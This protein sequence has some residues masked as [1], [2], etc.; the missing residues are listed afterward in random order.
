MLLWPVDSMPPTAKKQNKKLKTIVKLYS[1]CL[2]HVTIHL[3]ASVTPD[4]TLILEKY[5]LFKYA[6]L[7]CHRKTV[8]KKTK[9]KICFFKISV[10]VLFW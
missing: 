9:Q 4:N 6:Y 5:V 2:K 1:K 7:C 3:H 10:A 8:R